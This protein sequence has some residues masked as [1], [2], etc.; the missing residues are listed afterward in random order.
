MADL[1]QT[2]RD[3]NN[4]VPDPSKAPPTPQTPPPTPSPTPP[5]TPPGNETPPETPPAQQVKTIPPDPSFVR[6]PNEQATPPA[7]TVTPPTTPSKPG[8]PVVPVTPS[9]APEIIPDEKFYGHLSTLTDGTIKSEQDFG[10]FVERYNELEETVAKGIQP[11]FKNERAKLVHSIL[12][13]NEGME[14]QALMRIA[15]ALSFS[16]EGK[17]PKDILFQQYLMDPKNSDLTELTAQ[18][19]F[20]A[21]YD[22]KY[23]DM[24]S[25]LVRKREHDQAVKLATAEVSKF[26]NDLKVAEAPAQQVNTEL[27]GNITKAVDGFGGVKLAFTDNPQEADFLTVPLDNPQELAVLQDKI[28]NPDKAYNEFISQFDVRTEQGRLDLIRETWERENHKVLR[29]RAF[30]HGQKTERL[31]MVNQAANASTPKDVSQTGNPAAPAAA[32]NLWDAWADA[33]NKKSA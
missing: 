3:I 29:E 19:F 32:G 11:V 9:V 24:D 16:T 6:K 23:S 28:L 2:I 33:Q 15:R 20:N 31:K 18:E 22:A 14:P 13:E 1:L 7:A 27:I 30:E 25:N 8:E 26:Q 5:A 17:S 4:G 10:K 21:E 12:S